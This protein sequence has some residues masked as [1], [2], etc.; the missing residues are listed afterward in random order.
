MNEC[1]VKG[2]VTRALVVYCLRSC[3]SFRSRHFDSDWACNI[4]A[5]RCF[6]AGDRG[7]LIKFITTASYI[8]EKSFYQLQMRIDRINGTKSY[9]VGDI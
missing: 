5:L 9:L 3:E 2:Q 1:T 6:L 7:Q 4:K 8:T